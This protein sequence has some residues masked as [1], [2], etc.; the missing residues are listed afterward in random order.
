MRL[1]IFAF[2]AVLLVPFAASAQ[3]DI[4]WLDNYE[5]AKKA[6]R[7]TGKPIFLEYRCEP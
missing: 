6:A 4:Q 7:E 2:S 1:A 3:D 5:A